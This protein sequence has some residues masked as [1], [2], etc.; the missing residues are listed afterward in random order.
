MIC[1]W[2]R[3]YLRRLVL[4]LMRTNARGTIAGK[5]RFHPFG[6]TRFTTDMMFTDRLFNGPARDGG[7]GHLS[8]WGAVLF[9]EIGQVLEPG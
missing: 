6:E 1:Y 4:P 3:E 7:T 9:S 2:L 5:N 8:L